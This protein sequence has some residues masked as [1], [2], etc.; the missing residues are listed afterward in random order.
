MSFG[1]RTAPPDLARSRRPLRPAPDRLA[2]AL[3]RSPPGSLR[4]AVLQRLYQNLSEGDKS[5]CDIWS[6]LPQST[7][8]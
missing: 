6:G 4:E 2:Y 3:R 5:R 8:A 7:A 1:R